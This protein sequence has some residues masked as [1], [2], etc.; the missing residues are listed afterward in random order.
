MRGENTAQKAES[1]D[2]EPLFVPR[3]LELPCRE[4]NGIHEPSCL[5][6]AKERAFEVTELKIK[7]A[8]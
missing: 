7:T 1:R 4:E 6:Q 8:K 3:A 2:S 5:G